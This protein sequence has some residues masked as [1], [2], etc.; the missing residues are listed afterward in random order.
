MFAG[1]LADSFGEGEFWLRGLM[2]AA[3][4]LR[5]GQLS[6]LHST[7]RRFLSGWL[8]DR[9]HGLQEGRV[10][11][12]RARLRPNSGGGGG[13]VLDFDR[14]CRSG[15]AGPCGSFADSWPGGAS[16]Q[17]D[18]FAA[19]GGLLRHNGRDHLLFPFLG[20]GLGCGLVRAVCGPFSKKCAGQ[21]A[22]V[23]RTSRGRC[24]D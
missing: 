12:P 15:S 8:R 13:S 5:C 10:E 3:V 7:M 17:F 24:F 16:R 4:G 9:R 14:P 18:R 23:N 1:S 6:V 2:R 19:V 11:V 20:C 22:G 21:R